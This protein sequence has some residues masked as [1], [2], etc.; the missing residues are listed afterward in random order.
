MILFAP[1]V[2]TV[3]FGRAFRPA[4]PLVE[5][6]A[7]SGIVAA[8]SNVVGSAMVVTKRNR[9]LV[10]EGA[11]A[12]AFNV[13]GNLVLVPRFGVTASAW[14][15]V[16]TELG[17]CVG[18][19]VGMRRRMVFGPLLRTTI[20]PASAILAMIGAALALRHW[21]VVAMAV[22]VAT[23]VMVTVVLGGWPVELPCPVPRRL[24]RRGQ[25]RRAPADSDPDR[26]AG[27]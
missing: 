13:A 18:S 11:I 12:L 15:T 7:L 8:L 24:A 4:V 23:F 21:P 3:Y 26:A 16:A 27:S 6:L 9:W 5:I 14:L 2:V 22:A 25:P 10:T 17:V 1:Y 19:A 20:V